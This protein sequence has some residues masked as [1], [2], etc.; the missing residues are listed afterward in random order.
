MQA[1]LNSNAMIPSLFKAESKLKIK[2]DVDF[3]RVNLLSLYYV[4]VICKIVVINSEKESHYYCS[5]VQH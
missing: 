5:E 1:A 3:S 2:L 4:S